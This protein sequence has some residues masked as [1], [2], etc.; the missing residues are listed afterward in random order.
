MRNSESQIGASRNL[1]PVIQPFNQLMLEVPG[2]HTIYVEECGNP[3]GIPV[4]VFHGGPGGGCSPGMRRFFHPE[5][6][7]IILFD[8]RGCGR[9]R[10]HASVEN[11]TTWDLVADIELI[12]QKLG[13]ENW[14]VFGGS[15]GAT[16]ALVYAQTHPDR[17]NHL[18]LRGVFTMTKAELDWFYGGGAAAFFP[19]EWEHFAGLLPREERDDVIGN[20]AKRLFSNNEDVQVRFARAWTEWESALAALEQSPNRGVVPAAYALAFARIENHYFHNAGFLRENGQIF[21][22]L[23]KIEHIPGSIVQ[24]RYD[25]ICPPQTAYR[26]RDNWPAARLFTVPDAG[27]SLS[28]PGI[29]SALITIMD[30]LS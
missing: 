29:T 13:I 26:L 14:I 17:V 8:Q 7:R 10:P 24:G 18:V 30:E 25:M 1:Y 16:L 15:W 3:N 28:E 11:N 19:D 23:H 9:S 5:F 12:R 2:D 4:V 21:K 22:D 20:Y 27:H 6:Y